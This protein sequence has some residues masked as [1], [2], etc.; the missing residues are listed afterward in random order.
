MAILLLIIICI[1]FIGLGIPDSLFGSVWP[2][3]Y[4]E[5]GIP[6]SYAAFI[7]CAVSCGTILSSFFSTRVIA[8]HWNP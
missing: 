5:F 1:A 8:P 6:V 2:A 3:I 7:S 4:P